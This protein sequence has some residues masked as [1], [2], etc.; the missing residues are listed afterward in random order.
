[1]VVSK[2]QRSFQ[3]VV[4]SMRHLIIAIVEILFAVALFRALWAVSGAV[5]A[6]ADE[7]KASPVAVVRNFYK[8]KRDA[9]IP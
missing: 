4:D 8:E 2:R 9:D 1:M 5:V 3:V 7:I 6:V